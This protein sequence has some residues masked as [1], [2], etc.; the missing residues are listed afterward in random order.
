MSATWP[1]TGTVMKN[2]PAADSSNSGT[3][4]MMSAVDIS[5]SPPIGFSF[6]VPANHWTYNKTITQKLVVILLEYEYYLLNM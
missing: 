1:C 2:T 4:D 3:T 5:Q 6:Q